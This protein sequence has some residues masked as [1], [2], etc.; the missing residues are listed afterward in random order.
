MAL[1]LATVSNF[2]VVEASPKFFRQK[3][4]LLVWSMLPQSAG[5][6]AQVLNIQGRLS[7]R[8]RSSAYSGEQC[9]E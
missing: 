6:G 9:S 7:V 1:A 3:F 4:I 2:L 5:L 8:C